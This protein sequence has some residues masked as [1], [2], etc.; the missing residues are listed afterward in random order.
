[1]SD[2]KYIVGIDLGTTHCV[3]AYAAVQTSEDEKPSIQVF[4]IAQVVNPGEVK[5]QALLPSFLFLPGPHDVP[6]EGLSLPWNAK[7]DLSVGEFARRRGV[8]LPNRLVSSAKS[9]LC[10]AGVNRTASI[11]PWES[12]PDGRKV[13]PVEA[14]ALYLK[15]L[16]D[17]WTFEMDL[18]PWGEKW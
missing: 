10:H 6:A 17:A 13:S 9:W 18:R 14:C 7:M 8:E 16:R 1:M 4:P 15:H 3:L 2:P 12:P 11:L 5:A